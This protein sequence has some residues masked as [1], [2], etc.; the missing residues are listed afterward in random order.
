MAFTSLATAVCLLMV[1]NGCLA[2][3][4]SLGVYNDLSERVVDSTPCES[5]TNILN[6]SQ[7]TFC[8]YNR[9]IVN[10]IAIGT[11]R[12]IV[13]CQQNFANWRWNCTTFTGE[14]LF[15]AFV[16]NNTR[17]TAVI[18]AL[19]TAGAERQI[20]L[21]CRDEKLPNCTC[22]ING[23]NG[24]VNSTF[25]LYECSFDIAK[26]HDIMSKFLETPSNDDTAIIAEHNHNVGSNL[27]G[28]RYR[29][30]RCTG[31]SGSCSVQTCYFA[32]PD[33]DTIGQRVR[34]KYGSS[35]EVTVNASNSA[36]QPVVQTINNHDNELVYLK[37]SPTFCNQDTTYGI[38]GT[39]G[40]QCSNNLSDPDSCDIICCGRG[41][42]T[43]TAT[44][45][46]QCCSFIYCCRI[47]CQ[48]CGEETFTE[49][50]CK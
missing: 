16:K 32:S 43:V 48:D 28:Q 30:C 13:A 2:S 42:I 3:W 15:G 7:Q 31:F 4:W 44:Q 11:R 18:N 27:V 45:P 1:F 22:Q 34:E 24:V 8:N 29:K 41:H 14:N 36:L 33:I 6:S 5:L 12:G 21:D 49:Y 10:S 17:E 26:A 37:R 47:E 40:R 35:V 25:F 39:V 9:K 19:L 20:A 23:D 46:K 38:L 50:F